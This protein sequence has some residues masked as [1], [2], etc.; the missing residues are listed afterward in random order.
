MFATIYFSLILARAAL[1][2]DPPRLTPCKS[3]FQA[4]P[5]PPRNPIGPRDPRR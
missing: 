4:A 5:K 2:P 1:P 3:C